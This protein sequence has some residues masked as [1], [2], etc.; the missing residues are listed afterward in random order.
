MDLHLNDKHV[1]I[2]G[3]SKGIGLAC[4]VVFLE[5]G[6]KVSLVSRDQTNLDAARTALL[7]KFPGAGERIAVIAADLRD[8]ASAARALDQAEHALGDLAHGCPGP[9]A[10]GVA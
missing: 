9:D 6:A 8:A 5:E 4:A 1:L 7:E 10:R 3:G 2:T